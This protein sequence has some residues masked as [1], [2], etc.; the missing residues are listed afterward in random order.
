MTEI[1]LRVLAVGAS[2]AVLAALVVVFGRQL[3]GE[4]RRELV[5]QLRQ[6]RDAK[7]PIR[8]GESRMAG[9]RSERGT[10]D[11]R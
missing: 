2:L 4:V 3:R 8:A 6:H 10:S 7:G 11:R 1:A 9:A 5:R